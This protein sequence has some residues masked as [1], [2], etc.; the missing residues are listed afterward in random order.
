MSSTMKRYFAGEG[1]VDTAWDSVR[2]GA[3]SAATSRIYVTN[4]GGTTISVL[5]PATNKVV[6][7][8]K[9]IERPS[10]CDSLPTEA[11]LYSPTGAW[12]SST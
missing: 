9:G 11:A 6:E 3:L 2:S 4:R 8:I 12:T 1:Y 5:D 10:G 7:E